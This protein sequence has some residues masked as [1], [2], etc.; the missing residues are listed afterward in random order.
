MNGEMGI[1]PIPTSRL[2]HLD[3]FFQFSPTISPPFTIIGPW[4]DGPTEEK[5]FH[6][7]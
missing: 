2:E 6:A 1:F 4:T 7:R 3:V 5:W